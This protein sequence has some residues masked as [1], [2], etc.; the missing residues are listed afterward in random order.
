MSLLGELL[1][2]EPERRLLGRRPAEAG[3]KPHRHRWQNEPLRKRCQPY[4]CSGDEGH[5]L[6]VCPSTATE[7]LELAERRIRETQRRHE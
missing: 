7:V 1:Q 3:R 4:R 2:R 6:R 5:E